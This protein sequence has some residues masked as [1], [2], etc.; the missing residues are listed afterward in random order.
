MNKFVA[1]VVIKKD[2]FLLIKNKNR[3]WE[4]PGGKIKLNKKQKKAAKREFKEETGYN[5]V[6]P[7]LL[8]KKN[9]GYFYTGVLGPKR[10]N[11]ERNIRFFKELPNNLSFNKNEY[12]E[13]I[14]L[15]KKYRGKK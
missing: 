2:S 15:A 5:L 13:L 12:R 11:K 10:N 3:G 9:K 14:E 4:F 7:D 1:T 6:N 8:V